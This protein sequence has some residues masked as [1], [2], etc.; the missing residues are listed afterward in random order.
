MIAMS[1]PEKK[2]KAKAVSP[3]KKTLDQLRKQGRRV[4]VTERYDSHSHRRHDLF[5]F[6]DLIYLNTG[7]FGSVVGVHSTGCVP[8]V[9]SKSGR[10]RSG[11]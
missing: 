4:G 3:T 11:R 7:P 6:I 2:K 8:A 10:G 9:P 1:P 5:G